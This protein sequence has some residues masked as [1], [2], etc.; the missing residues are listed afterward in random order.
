MYDVAGVNST[1]CGSQP[2][3]QQCK[4]W[5]CMDGDVLLSRVWSI[6]L[7]SHKWVLHRAFTTSVP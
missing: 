2:Q 1:S 4:S 7:I 5:A 6:T 3:L